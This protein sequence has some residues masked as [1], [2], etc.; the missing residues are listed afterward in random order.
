M[1]G[2]AP[3]PENAKQIHIDHPFFY[4]L[5]LTSSKETLFF[6]KIMDPQ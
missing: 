6:G 3:P 4:F 1:L 2:S 5:Q